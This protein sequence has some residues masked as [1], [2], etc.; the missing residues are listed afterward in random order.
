[1]QETNATG[2]P[3]VSGHFY[4]RKNRDVGQSMNLV[5]ELAIANLWNI[6]FQRLLYKAFHN[7]PERGAIGFFSNAFDSPERPIFSDVVY[8]SK[9]VSIA[10]TMPFKWYWINRNLRGCCKIG[11]DRD[12]IRTVGDGLNETSE[13]F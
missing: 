11:N 1:M 7:N 6:V 9:P 2:G 13:F 3:E 4:D 5:G 8:P 10:I 12:A